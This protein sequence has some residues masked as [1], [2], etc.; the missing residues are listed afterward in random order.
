M[1]PSDR[2][3]SL[4]ARTAAVFLD[5]DGTLLG[6][7]D[8]P[9]DVVADEALID[10]L[11]RLRQATDGALALNSGRMLA[12]ID[13]IVAPLTLP[14][15]GTH[16][17]EL[18][19]PNGAVHSTGPEAL[20][21][22]RGPLRAF[23]EAHPGAMLEEKGA[24]IGLHYRMAPAMGERIIGFLDDLLPRH[25]LEVQHGKLVADVKSPASDKGRA[26]AEL[27]RH[28][29]FAGRTPVF[30]GDDL[31]DEKGFA[32]VN[33]M[34]GASVKVGEG[35]TCAGERLDGLPEVRRYLEALLAA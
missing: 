23:V 21:A 1:T 29:P 14:A 18:R 7:K 19:F 32:A 27:M 24:A 26:I 8:R 33:A 5:I 35:G 9:G 13:R 22:V 28:P 20:D 30:L 16:G 34:G 17:A 6:F 10:L 25:G 3:P 4:A 15:A 12:D 31:T 2:K 11:E